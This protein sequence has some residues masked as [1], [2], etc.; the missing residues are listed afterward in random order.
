MTWLAARWVNVPSMSTC[1]SSKIIPQIQVDANSEKSFS[2]DMN[3]CMASEESK[4]EV[5]YIEQVQIIVTMTAQ[6]RGDIELFVVSPFN[7][8]TQILPVS[9]FF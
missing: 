3:Q 5:N 8:T 7:T 1:R 4:E 6:R 9:F 2:F